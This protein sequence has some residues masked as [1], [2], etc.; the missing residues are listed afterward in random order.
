[1]IRG[2]VAAA[3]LV[4]WGSVAKADWIGEQGRD[5]PY[6]EAGNWHTGIRLHTDANR[7]AGIEADDPLLAPMVLCNAPGCLS[8][9]SVTLSPWDATLLR[10]LFAAADPAAE[11][12]RRQIATAI[13]LLEHVV[14]PVLGTADD[15]PAND[16]RD[17]ETQGQLDCIA[18]TVNTLTY[19]DR[20]ALAGLLRHHDVSHEV[21]RFTLILQHIAVEIIDIATGESWVVDSWPG[22]NAEEPVIQPYATWRGEWQA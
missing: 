6:A 10:D 9:L 11:D 13:A 20:L 5:A 1:V 7:W 4:A 15:Q 17:W 18:E 19:L 12:E 8:Q 3:V 2:L 14:A 21:I 22:A 16:H